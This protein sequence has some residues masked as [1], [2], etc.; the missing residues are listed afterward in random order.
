MLLLA[1]DTSTRQASIALCSESELLGE[2]SWHIGNNHS[3][4]LLVHIQRLVVECGKT[5][6]DIEAVA[7]ARG[8]GCLLYTSDAADE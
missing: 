7:V 3:T 5:M 8:P 4:E 2:Y 6:A 1:L